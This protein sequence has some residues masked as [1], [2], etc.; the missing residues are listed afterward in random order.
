MST[1]CIANFYWD[2][3]TVYVTGKQ[4]IL[5]CSYNLTM[6]SQY[7]AKIEFTQ[8]TKTIKMHDFLECEGEKI[9]QDAFET[10]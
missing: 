2:C 5:S 7:N 8:F 6:N 1:V 4:K 9:D 3:E 10:L